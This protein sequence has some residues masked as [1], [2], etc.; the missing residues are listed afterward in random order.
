MN[1]SKEDFK[2]L[3]QLDRIEYLVKG[4][5]LKQS[6][7]VMDFSVV[8]LTFELSGFVMILG[9]LLWNINIQYSTKFLLLIPLIFKLG[10][11]IFFILGFIRVIEGIF[12][13]KKVRAL[14]E[15]YFKIEVKK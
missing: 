13:H 1:I 8:N 2:K 11:I 12:Y 4:H 9:L 15:E 14:K 10:S 5:I 7:P 6:K 3:K